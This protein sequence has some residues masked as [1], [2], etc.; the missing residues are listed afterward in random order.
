MSVASDYPVTTPWG[1]SADYPLNGGRHKGE[2]H[3]MPT[4]TPVLVNGVLIGHSNNTGYSTGPHL[5]IGKW[6]GGV[7]VN[8]VGGGFNL[9]QPVTVTDYNPV[10]AND[11]TNGIWVGLRDGAGVRWVYLHLQQTAVVPGQV[12]DNLPKFNAQGEEDMINDVDNEYGRWNKLFYQIR[13]RNASRDEFRQSAVGQNWL[14]AMEILSDDA[15][16]DN[17]T[18]A[19]DVGQVAVRDAWDQQ[20]H[21]LQDQ[22]KASQESVTSANDQLN[23]ILADRNATKAQLTD[24]LQK[25]TSLTAQVQKD[26]Q[27]VLDAQ[28]KA[29]QPQVIYTHD[30]QLTKDVGS[31]KGML[32]NFI[33]YVKNKLG[34]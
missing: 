31:I 23:T 30:E 33:G 3:A 26:Q 22:L 6:I 34:R 18:H 14:H 32:I 2:D 21:T 10:A 25:V 16:A 20:I 1:Y 28:A 29:A 17:A 12:L 15:E 4:G 11:M 7:D 24:A 9:P 5:H 27:S 19:Q 13:G 8:P